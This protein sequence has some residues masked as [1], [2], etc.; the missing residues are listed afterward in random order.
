M[1]QNR[2]PA[3]LLQFF[4]IA[5]IDAKTRAMTVSIHDIDSKNLHKVVIQPEA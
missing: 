5:K 2:S 4:G 1:K 3:E